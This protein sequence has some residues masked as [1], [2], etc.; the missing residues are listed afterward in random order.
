MPDFIFY[1]TYPIHPTHHLVPNSTARHAH[2]IILLPIK[3]TQA[4]AA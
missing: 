2:S 4:Q 3:L 1:R